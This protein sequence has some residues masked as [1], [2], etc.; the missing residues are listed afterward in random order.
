MPIKKLRC[1]VTFVIEKDDDEFYAYCPNLKGLHTSG[2]TKDEALENAKCA[3]EAYIESL[4]AHE[5]PIPL[6][7]CHEEIPEPASKVRSLKTSLVE[8]TV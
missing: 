6:A 3:V 4:L 8:V 5:E 2:K 1:R 7:C